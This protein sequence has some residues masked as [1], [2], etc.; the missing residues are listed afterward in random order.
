MYTCK[1]TVPD[2]SLNTPNLTSICIIIYGLFA[3]LYNTNI[4]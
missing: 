4:I 2:T 1:Y 3:T